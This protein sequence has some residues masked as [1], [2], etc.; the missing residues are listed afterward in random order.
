MRTRTS[1]KLATAL[2]ALATGFGLGMPAVAAA[3]TTSGAQAT[4]YGIN[5]PGEVTPDISTF[6]EYSG[7]N[8]TGSI[9]GF[10]CVA[11][12]HYTLG[13]SIIMDPVK[14][15]TNNCEYRV[16]L[17]YPGPKQDCVNP[18]TTRNIVDSAFQNPNGVIIGSHPGE[19]C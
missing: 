15:V 3:A 1:L 9:D 16:Y 4:Q 5:T 14:S 8:E 13:N 18:H 6:W 10:A 17:Q 7:S 12:A 11:G 2:A 19:K